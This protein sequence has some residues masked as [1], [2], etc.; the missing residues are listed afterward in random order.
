MNLREQLLS[1]D[2][3]SWIDVGCGGNFENGFWHLDTFPSES[4]K[5]EYRSQYISF[6]I[7]NCLDSE[8]R[9]LGLFDL[10]RMQHTLEHFTYEEGRQVLINSG[11]LLKPGGLL[12]VTVPDLEVHINK[13][14]TNEYDSWHGFKQWA[15][16]RIPDN[17]PRSFYFSIF[18]YSMPYESHKWCY[19]Y[20]GLLYQISSL[21]MYANIKR[22]EV[23]DPLANVPFTH[24][25]PEEDLCVLATMK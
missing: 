20:E 11:K 24:N 3:T 12:L 5:N 13:Y 1:E 7:L 4:I 10:V 14:L 17:A 19:D 21:N 23:S 25:R 2:K 22:L 18:A 6:D 8:L 15:N 9:E 16:K